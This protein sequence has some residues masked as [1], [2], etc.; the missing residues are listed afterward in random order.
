[1][2]TFD[3]PSFLYGVIVGLIIGLPPACRLFRYLMND[4]DIDGAL[5][6]S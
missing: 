5:D 4:P 6:E 2:P 3:I 1:M